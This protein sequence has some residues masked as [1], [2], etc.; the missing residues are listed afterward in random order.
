LNIMACPRCTLCYW[1]LSFKME[2]LPCNLD[3]ALQGPFPPG[4][5]LTQ[6]DSACVSLVTHPVSSVISHHALS[7]RQCSR[8]E[9][10][11]ALQMLIRGHVSQLPPPAP[12]T[13][14]QT[15]SEIAFICVSLSKHLPLRFCINQ[16]SALWRGLLKDCGQP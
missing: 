7:S 9:V 15:V 3:H 4:T 13:V 5:D 1:L 12:P 8:R 11:T 6:A 2:S 14:A 10:H 16:D